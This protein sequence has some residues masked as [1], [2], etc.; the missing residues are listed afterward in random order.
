MTKEEQAKRIAELEAELAAQGKEVARVSGAGSVKPAIFAQTAIFQIDN[1]ITGRPPLILR[2]SKTGEGAKAKITVQ[3]PKQDMPVKDLQR[4]MALTGLSD[5]TISHH[6][7]SPQQ[8]REDLRFGYVFGET[9]ASINPEL[10]RVDGIGKDSEQ[11]AAALPQYTVS[12]GTQK[13]IEGTDEA[14]EPEGTTEPETAPPVPQT[15]AAASEGT[16]PPA[17]APAAQPA[18]A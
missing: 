6:F 10:Q 3:I 5:T 14:A 4:I 13:Q 11:Y 18:Q 9:I 16:A 2:T 17:S 8:S 7:K 12:L 15:G 1:K